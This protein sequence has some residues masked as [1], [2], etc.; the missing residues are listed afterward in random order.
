[1]PISICAIWSTK[2]K[3][4]IALQIHRI[5]WI[6]PAIG[7]GAE[8]VVF[9]T[10]GIDG[11]EAHDSGIVVAG[12]IVV[13]VQAV[14]LVKLLVVVLVALGASVGALAEEVAEGII[15]VHLFYRTRIIDHNA[16]VALVVAEIGMVG[17]R[18]PAEGDVAALGEYL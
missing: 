13:P 8:M 6:I 18:R 15:M 11:G 12:A 16:V 3:K 14:H 7:I 5:H 10:H 17:R 2:N 4:S 9:L 1:M